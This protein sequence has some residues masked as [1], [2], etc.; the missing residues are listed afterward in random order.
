MSLDPVRG[1]RVRR[2][3]LDQ[4]TW[5]NQRALPMKRII[6]GRG[7]FGVIRAPVD[8]SNIV[9]SYYEDPN[10]HQGR[11]GSVEELIA[12]GWAVD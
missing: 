9:I 3:V 6:G 8:P 5:P 2:M 10:R 1:A 7:E 4:S 12:D 11:F